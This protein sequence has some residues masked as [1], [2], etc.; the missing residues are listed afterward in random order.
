MIHWQIMTCRFDQDM[1]QSWKLCLTLKRERS[2]SCVSG[3]SECRKP[4]F[5]I[6]WRAYRSEQVKRWRGGNRWRVAE[7]ETAMAV[8][9]RGRQE[10][11]NEPSFVT[12][13]SVPIVGCGSQLKGGGGTHVNGIARQSA[14][15]VMSPSSGVGAQT[16]RSWL[17][18][19]RLVFSACAFPLV[20]LF[21]PHRPRFFFIFSLFLLLAFFIYSNSLLLL[22]CCHVRRPFLP[23]AN[24]TL[25]G[26]DF[27]APN[28]DRVSES[29]WRHYQSPL[30]DA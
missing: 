15:D 3:M 30:A 26:P 27:V 19:S 9:N 21:Q 12:L 20:F 1:G 7:D 29:K 11:S 10:N 28:G 6:S 23:L 5:L 24:N 13:F 25:I 18:F 22:C 14:H 8:M 4:D 17:F 16:A 2:Y